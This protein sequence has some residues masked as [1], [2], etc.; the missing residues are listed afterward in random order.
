VP[1][2]VLAAIDMPVEGLV[3]MKDELDR[4][5]AELREAGA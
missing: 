2:D 4:L 1:L 5:S 3:K